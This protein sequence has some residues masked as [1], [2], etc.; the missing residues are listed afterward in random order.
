MIEDDLRKPERARADT[1]KSPDRR[2][3]NIQVQPD[4]RAGERR[5][6]G[7]PSFTLTPVQPAT[8]P[9]A[10]SVQPQT[11]RLTEI[12][13]APVMPAQ[14][15]PTQSQPQFHAPDGAHVAAPPPVLQN[16]VRMDTPPM[17]PAHHAPDH[18][19]I[20]SP[21]THGNAALAVAPVDMV[22]PEGDMERSAKPAAIR[23][24][25]MPRAP[26]DASLP[27][28]TPI[29]PGSRVGRAPMPSAE[30][31][32]A[33][34]A[35][36]EQAQSLQ[37]NASATLNPS[38][39]I[40]AARRAA[41]AA[42]Q[43]SDQ[44]AKAAP[45][46]APAAKTK[47]G[48][49]RS[50]R[51]KAA[52]YQPDPAPRVTASALPGSDM[53]GDPAQ[54][55]FSSKLRQLLVGACVVVIV[56]GT[57]RVG[58]NLVNGTLFGGGNTETA[59]PAPSDKS[60]DIMPPTSRNADAGHTGNGGTLTETDKTIADKSERAAPNG[61]SMSMLDRPSVLAPSTPAS[62]ASPA[63]SPSSG[64]IGGNPA[65]TPAPVP[66]P[67][68]APA[69]APQ[70]SPEPRA[71]QSK[72]DESKRDVTGS[73]AAPKNAAPIAPMPKIAAAPSAPANDGMNS[74]NINSVPSIPGA[75]GALPDKI[76]AVAL[77]EAAIKGD[78][79]AAFEIAV[80]FAEGKGVPVNYPEAAMWYERA[81]KAGIVPAMFR[82]GSLYE[83]GLGVKK[84][85]ATARSYYVAAAERGNAKAMHNLAVLFADGGGKG[86]DYANAA[87]WFRK[88][89]DYGLADSQYNLAILYARGIGVP[90]NLAESYKWFSLAA[91][92]AIQTPRAN[93][94]MWPSA[95]MH[96]P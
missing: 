61:A 60:S 72:S 48:L 55:T 5:G 65:A 35:A 18:G 13:P 88:A 67:A 82:I 89:A 41:K 12:T 19:A 20:S 4:M 64:F 78:A 51:K 10:P 14:N 26:I 3:V 31:I 27:P 16:P 63:A 56:L 28:D 83:K 58:M 84:D 37:G 87:K 23:P 85:M 39:F 62:I 68:P 90:Q 33:S 2:Q 75:S 92:Q 21:M 57:L 15:M 11:M 47:G 96:N 44:S 50:D 17:A 25:Q 91:A 77:R 74:A 32:A 79:S 24:P 49:F 70:S 30:R 53:A 8:Q 86:P 76:G 38:N 7:G 36:L 45:S 81:A 34:E 46:D 73:V 54:S 59:V 43:S 22:L 66:A 42:G 80:R 52:P 1:Q 69:P 94:T 6:N 71:D 9:G 40:A 95:S 29:E 93:A